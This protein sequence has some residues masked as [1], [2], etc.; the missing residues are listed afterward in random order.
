VTIVVGPGAGAEEAGDDDVA[1][2]LARALG[3]GA[4]VKDATATVSAATGRAKREVYAIALGLAG[5]GED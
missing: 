1:S 4:S 2:R 5:K 3:A